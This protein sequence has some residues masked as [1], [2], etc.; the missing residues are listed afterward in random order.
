MK[1]IV[2]FL[3]LFLLQSAVSFSQQFQDTLYYKSGWI[4]PVTITEI[5]NR[6]IYFLCEGKNG[7]RK[8][9]ISMS[10]LKGF[11]SVNPD[12][13]EIQQSEFKYSIGDPKDTLI[14]NIRPGLISISPIDIGLWGIGLDYSYR[15]KDSYHSAL[16]IPF[17]ASTFLANTVYFS[18]GAGYSYY[19][20]ASSNADFYMTAI[21]TFVAIDGDLIGAA[22]LGFGTSVYFN[23]NLAFNAYLGAGPAIGATVW[24]DAQVGIG[25]RFG[26]KIKAQLIR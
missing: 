11:T 15:F 3:L 6:N 26:Q 24:F 22:I 5:K 16:H 18:V 14:Y 10:K 8:S 13:K 7:P 19:A 2:T 9:N 25:F 17:R 23:E 1:L 21:P 20:R 4:R 12:F